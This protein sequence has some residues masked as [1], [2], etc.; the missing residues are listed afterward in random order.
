V[1]EIATLVK[2]VCGK[3]EAIMGTSPTLYANK[4]DVSLIEF[5]T[6]TLFAK[7]SFENNSN[8]MGSHR[9]PATLPTRRPTRSR[10]TCVSSRV[11]TN[12][13]HNP[14]IN[15]TDYLR[16]GFF[17]YSNA[18]L[19]IIRVAVKVCAPAHHFSV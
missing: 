13:F 6:K 8:A 11:M 16:L 2:I 18:M 17:N 15:L 19:F 5:K 9:T 14:S 3:G 10:R 1:E 12:A 4:C 7:K